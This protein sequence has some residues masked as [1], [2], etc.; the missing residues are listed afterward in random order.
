M[1]LIKVGDRLSPEEAM[2]EAIRVA[3]F[4]RGLVA[5]NPLV[6]CVIVDKNH[7]FLASGAHLKWG[8]DHAEIQ[9]LK[10]IKQASDLE[11]ATVYVTLEPCSHTGKT[12]PCA[13]ALAQTQISKVVY[14]TVD[15]FPQVSG[16]GLKFLSSKGIDLGHFISMET[17]CLQLIEEF[18]HQV[19][20]DTPYVALKLAT[21]IDGQMALENGDSRWITGPETRAHA[22]NLRGCHEATLVGAG[23]FLNDDPM[24]NFRDTPFDSVKRNKIV[25]LDPKGKGANFFPKSRLKQIHNLE[26]I[27]I[28][29]PSHTLQNWS[30]HGVQ[31]IPWEP[32]YLSWVK[33]LKFLRTS[34][35]HS[36]FVEGGSFAFSQ[37]LQFKLFQKVY[38]YQAPKIIGKGLSWSQGFKIQDLKSAVPLESWTTERVG[39]DLLFTARSLQSERY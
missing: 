8:G 33:A 19:H 38:I 39:E 26:D 34:G 13:E 5:P 35:V 36:L 10:N 2:S 29:G 24:L 4:G 25:I 9:A 6:G 28:L 22:R 1:A 12:P 27:C 20:S 16:N 31:T 37:F 30:E 14:G 7:C 23:T 11:G 17:E 15:P 21:S 3:N 32:S 18:R